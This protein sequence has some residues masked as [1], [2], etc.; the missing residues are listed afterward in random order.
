MVHYHFLTNKLKKR[1]TVTSVIFYYSCHYHV[2]TIFEVS[3]SL[4]FPN[5]Y[6]TKSCPK[7]GTANSSHRGRGRHCIQCNKTVCPSSFW[8]GGRCSGRLDTANRPVCQK[9]GEAQHT[10]NAWQPN[11]YSATWSIAACAPPPQK[12]DDVVPLPCTTQTAGR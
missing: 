11:P 2:C 1:V 4:T 7:S 10:G 3:L 12:D 8:G 5:T 6:L 9:G